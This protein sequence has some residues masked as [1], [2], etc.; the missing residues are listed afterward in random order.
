M[1]EKIRTKLDILAR[2]LLYLSPKMRDP[3]GPATDG[4]ARRHRENET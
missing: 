2:R 3:G 4:G 1:I